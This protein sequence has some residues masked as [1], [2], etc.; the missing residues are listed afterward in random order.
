MRQLK[1]A[2]AC[3]PRR[4]CF[5]QNACAAYS[6]YSLISYYLTFR[7]LVFALSSPV[8]NC[9]RQR[10][11]IMLTLTMSSNETIGDFDVC[12]VCG[13]KVWPGAINTIRIQ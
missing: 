13:D 11:K 10:E 12:A 8:P 1:R 6:A 5:N 4:T 7:A 2:L 3:V 9:A